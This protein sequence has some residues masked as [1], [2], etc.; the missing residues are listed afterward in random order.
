MFQACSGHLPFSL[1]G[2]FSF[3]AHTLPGLSLISGHF[4]LPLALLATLTGSSLRGQGL[5]GLQSLVSAYTG[6]C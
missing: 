4:L 3:S 1:S 5:L 2:L 6:A